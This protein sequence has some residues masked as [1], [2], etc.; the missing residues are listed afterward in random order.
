MIPLA[1][2][3]TGGRRIA[4]HICR[5]QSKP[6]FMK[7]FEDFTNRRS[8]CRTGF[9]L[10]ELLIVV[11]IIGVLA[12]LM[13]PMIRSM[14]GRANL[15]KCTANLRVWSLVIR[16]YS[17]DHNQMVRYRDWEDIGNTTKI[18]NPYFGSEKT[19]WPEKGVMGTT[20]GYHRM[21][22]GQHWD[23]EGNPPRGYFFVRP[24]ELNP[25]GKYSKGVVDTDLDG[26]EDSYS[27]AKMARPSQLLVMMDAEQPK[28]VYRTSEF[29]LYVEPIC[30][31]AD[32]S[33]IRHGGGVN[34]L[35]GD[36]HIEF[37][38]WNEINPDNPANTQ[39]VTTWLNLD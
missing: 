8:Q 21:C 14:Q 15:T 37:L 27:L 35:F 34:A 23:G 26:L 10:V 39:K 31:N 12:A 38:K 22:P 11:I 28:S 30:V 5:F 9:T 7:P 4:E 6:L 13:F 24:N 36:G 33:K 2:S 25:S 17:D 18:Y 19:L 1:Y 16:A 32:K 3:L 29:N 20:Q